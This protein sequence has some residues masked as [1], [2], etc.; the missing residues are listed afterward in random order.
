MAIATHVNTEGEL[1]SR[2]TLEEEQQDFDEITQPFNPEKIKVRTVPILVDQVVSRINHNE[3]DLAPEFQRLAGIWDKQRK[4]RLIESLLLRIPIPV[5]YVAAD[6]DD[7]WSMVDGVQRTST[8]FD[9]V[10]GLFPLSRLEYL[11]YLNGRHHD[12]LPRKMQRRIGETQFVVH[13]I[14]P[15]TP[16]EVMFNIFLRLNTGGK[17]LNGQE[18]RHALHAGPVRDYLP[19]LADT[20]AFLNATSGTIS[21]SRMED[22]ELVLR[23]LAFYVEPWEE[24]STNDLDGYLGAVMNKINGMDDPSTRFAR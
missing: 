6:E 1:E 14:D 12:D 21:K 10:S 3:I 8:V 20:E 15:G 13:V 19:E 7:V 5:F 9:F 23:F 18:I 22:R 11:T 16:K 17:P 2:E 4:S 24:Y